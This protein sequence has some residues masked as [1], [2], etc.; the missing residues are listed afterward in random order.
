MRMGTCVRKGFAV[1]PCLPYTYRHKMTV[2]SEC[3]KKLLRAEV[4]HLK[5]KGDME[6]AIRLEAIFGK[7]GGSNDFETGKFIA[8]DGQVL[9]YNKWKSE[10]PEHVLIFINGLESHAGWFSGMAADLVKKRIAIYGLDRRGSGLNVR[11]FG[12]FEA[13][14]NDIN[15]LIKRTRKENPGAKI[16]LISV[17]FGAKS[18]TA[19]A[20]RKA[21]RFDSLIYLSPGMSVRV[22]PTLIE[23]LKIGLSML[24]W[25]SFNVRSPIRDDEMFT[26][27]PEAL[28]FL[29]NDR[30][31][32][33]SPR[34]SVF[35][36][37]K[38]IDS[39]ISKNSDKV[40]IPSL[41]LLA[42]KDQ[43]VDNAKTKMAFQRFDQKPKIIEYHESEHVI[44]FGR[45][46]NKLTGDIA[47][48]IQSI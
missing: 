3:Y 16:H 32:T 14:I 20:I 24:P 11:N 30:L 22:K 45:A 19:C 48:F 2:E 6:T 46:K 29:Y 33:F 7:V 13:W 38:K 36:Q 23:K 37:S 8:L 9:Y 26:D 43:I 39:Y 21:E 41:V 1:K 31:R 28:Y 44:F 4:R 34:A 12:K 42:G 5:E 35:F 17:C 15:R 10:N 47:D 27:S 25:L 40:K 18:V